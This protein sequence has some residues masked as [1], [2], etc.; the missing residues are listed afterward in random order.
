MHSSTIAKLE[1]E[2]QALTAEDF[3][4]KVG[5]ESLFGP[6]QKGDVILGQCLESL[7]RLWILAKR[8]SGLLEA[9][10]D[11]FDQLGQSPDHLGQS[12][13]CCQRLEEECRI[14]DVERFLLKENF[15]RYLRR[16]FGVP[17]TGPSNLD[18]RENGTVVRTDKIKKALIGLRQMMN[19]LI[20][21]RN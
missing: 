15:W 5:Q 14:L 8:K 6:I 13:V 20:A 11:L 1:A 4:P 17:A 2:A 19:A 21:G 7:L 16:K 18:V 9:K 12:S 10:Q 3:R